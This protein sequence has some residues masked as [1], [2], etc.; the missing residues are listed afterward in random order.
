VPIGRLN[1]FFDHDTERALL[2]GLFL[3]PD[4]MRDVDGLAPGDFHEDRNRW[5]FQA[6][7]HIYAAEGDFTDLAALTAE[8]DAMGKLKELQDGA[9]LHEIVT[10]HPSPTNLPTHIARVR[11]YA[12]KRTLWLEAQ[13]LLTRLQS[14]DYD[15]MPADI[16]RDS[17]VGKLRQKIATPEHLRAKHTWTM[18]E[19]LATKFPEMQWVVPGLLPVGLSWLAGRPKL[20]KSW[21]GLQI[22]IAVGSGGRLFEQRLHKGRVLF[23]AFEDSARR[24]QDRA[25]KQGADIETQVTFATDWPTFGEGGL[26]RLKDAIVRQDYGLVVIDTF[27]RA[28]GMADQRDPAQMT[29]LI[30]ELQDTA[31]SQDMAMLVIDHHRKSANYAPDPIDDIIESTA[32]GAVID[33]AWGLYKERGKQGA[34]LMIRGRDVEDRELALQWDGLTCCWQY[35]GE[36]DDVRSDT[37]KGQILGAIDDLD[38]LGE[39]A[40]Q[41]TIADYLDKDRGNV[42]HALADLLN[43]GKI[44]KAEKTGRQQPYKCTHT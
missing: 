38:K 13:D 31:Q 26:T 18:D 22:S 21:L 33:T 37:L 12:D 15:D 43:D 30:G 29:M 2:G 25:K 3:S 27:S 8:L 1:K 4:E 16:I 19:L 23:L 7:R 42:G 17:M 40:T 34:T 6:M 11:D 44:F 32:K 39:L 10:L 5:I 20:G 36:A 28:A 14:G 9:Y 41:T 35:E 24:L